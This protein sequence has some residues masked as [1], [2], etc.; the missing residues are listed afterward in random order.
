MPLTGNAFSFP[1]EVSLMEFLQTHIPAAGISVIS[2]FSM[3]GEELFMVLVLGLLYWGI[4]KRYGKYVGLNV[5][6]GTIWNP[7]A[8]NI[9]MRRRPYF[10]H[11][12]IRILRVV[13]P[14]ADIYD[15]SA[16]GYSFPSGHSTCAAGLFG[17]L[18][19]YRKNKALTALAVALPLL[20]GFSRVVVGAHYPT[21]VLVGWLFGA[22]AIWIVPLL[23]RRIQSDFSFYGVLLLTALPG[24]FFCRSADYFT[25]LGL[26]VGFIVGS[27]IEERYVRFSNTRHPLRVLL[28]VA[29]GAALFF[30]LNALLKRPFSAA[31]LAG[32]T[33]AALLVRT[34]RYALIAA[35]DFAV[36]PMAF[37][38]I[39]PIRRLEASK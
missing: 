33:T 30:V 18:A 4:D 25:G 7:M 36:Y 2:F 11:E 37:D 20:V 22:L 8:K 29:G 15:I 34:A 16:Q 23:R 21:D 26:L 39:A 19:R 38:R 1:W 5:L 14:E 28:R 9:A 6:M 13:E 32:G 10:D 17:S 27:V 35:I 12:G 24:I 31:F 3:F